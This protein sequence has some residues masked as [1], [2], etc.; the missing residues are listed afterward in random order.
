MLGMVVG[1]EIA[2]VTITNARDDGR[3]RGR[4]RGRWMTVEDGHRRW[5]MGLTRWS[6]SSPMLGLAGIVVGDS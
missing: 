3:G 6:A 2:V 4:G 1:M 5:T